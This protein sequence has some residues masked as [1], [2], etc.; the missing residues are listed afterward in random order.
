MLRII[1]KTKIWFGISLLIILIGATAI[2]KNHGLEFGIDFKGGTVVA[3]DMEKD[4]NKE[5]PKLTA[6]IKKYAPDASTSK[7]ND[8]STANGLEIKSA[9]LK[10]ADITKLFEEVK[11]AYSLK[12][13]A[14]VQQESIGA[15]LGSEMR[16]KAYFAVFIAVMAMLLYIAVRFEISF[17]LAAIVSL[18]HDVLITVA[19]YAIF[20]ISVDSAFI[21]AILTVIG[22]S[23]NDTIVVF[24][25]IRENKKYFKKND[26]VQLGNASLTQTMARSINTVATVIIMLIVL[27]IFV[28]TIRNFSMPLLVGI[29]SGC[30]SSIFIA[31]PFWVIFSKMNLKKS[32]KPS[33]VK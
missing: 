26:V 9:N 8:T 16:N 22:Y 32:I 11:T 10:E 17:G 7:I 14:P 5:E 2:I 31:T 27:Y 29:I 4:F 33:T 24:D 23:I 21:A 6:I 20:K 12:S 15:S 19:F 1:E 28:P 30:Y 18:I 13:T 25:R 3:I